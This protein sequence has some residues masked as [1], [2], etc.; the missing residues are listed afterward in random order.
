[1]QNQPSGVV[2]ELDRVQIYHEPNIGSFKS[3]FSLGSSS[4]KTLPVEPSVRRTLKTTFN[5][6][7]CF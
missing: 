4:E 2:L 3:Q 1:M 6:L 5:F 7:I